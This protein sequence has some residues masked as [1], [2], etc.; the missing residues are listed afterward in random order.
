MGLFDIFKKSE[1]AKANEVQ[2]VNEPKLQSEPELQSAQTEF[3]EQATGIA[4]ITTEKTLETEV[5]A[6]DTS[7]SNTSAVETSATAV[8]ATDTAETAA[9]TK[10]VEGYLGDLMKTQA[11]LS[12]VEVPIEQRDAEWVGHFLN[13]LPLASFRCGTPQVIAGPDGFPYFQLFLP[14]SGEKFQCFVVEHM[15]NDFL[16]ERGYGIVIN[17]GEGQPDWVLTYGDIL[18]YHL[19]KSFFVQDDSLFST[20]KSDET[21]QGEITVGQ[22]SELILPAQTR[23]LLRD[24]FVLNGIEDPKILLLSRQATEG[25]TMDLA[26]NITPEGFE[27]DLHYR[28]MMQTVTWYLPRHYSI[29]GLNDNGTSNGFMPL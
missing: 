28:N 14:K 22:P 19:N 4:D 6:V 2:K 29:V 27:S 23:A 25:V 1:T 3:T 17:P 18:N 10:K 15:I 5:S 12:L 8:S 16:L 11:L 26:F 9:E 20:N 7:V 24:F 21:I 13:D